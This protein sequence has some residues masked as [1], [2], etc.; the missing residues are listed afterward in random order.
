MTRV[1][2]ETKRRRAMSAVRGHIRRN[3]DEN[4]ADFA[5]E[6]AILV[7]CDIAL[8][9]SEAAVW[10]KAASDGQV[11]LFK[12]DWR[13]WRRERLEWRGDLEG[14]AALEKKS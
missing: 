7:L 10:F 5:A 9:D 6:D 14:I 2:V 13:K 3:H 12:R 11:A 4:P 1:N 8:G